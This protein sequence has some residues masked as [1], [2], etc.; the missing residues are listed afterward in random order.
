[1]PPAGTR[2][3]GAGSG[4]RVGQ[5]VARTLPTACVCAVARQRVASCQCSEEVSVFQFRQALET[6]R[7]D[8]ADDAMGLHQLSD[9]YTRHLRS[10]VGGKVSQ[11]L[12]RRQVKAV[13]KFM[14]LHQFECSFHN[15]THMGI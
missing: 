15:T 8:E 12:A 13:S 5:C 6:A 1:M 7:H 9:A 10:F 14:A 4:G 11:D 2:L 3:L